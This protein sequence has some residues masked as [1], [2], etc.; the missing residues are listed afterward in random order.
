MRE[1][2][3]EILRRLESDARASETEARSAFEEEERLEPD[4]VTL[5]QRLEAAE[6]NAG[7]LRQAAEAADEK[8]RVTAGEAEAAAATVTELGDLCASIEKDGRRSADRLERIRTRLGRR[9]NQELDLARRAVARSTSR[10]EDARSRHASASERAAAA[11]A[12]AAARRQEATEARALATR[13]ADEASVLEERLEGMFDRLTD[14]RTA[15]RAAMS[16]A[17]MKKKILEGWIE[18]HGS[19]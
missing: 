15:S 7:V 4:Y 12:V 18:T 16:R 11:A 3:L 10:L 14:L 8:A 17:W 6:A 13:A 1:Q 5:R 9:V 2:I 19:A